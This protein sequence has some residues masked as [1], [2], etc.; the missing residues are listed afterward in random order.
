MNPSNPFYPCSIAFLLLALKLQVQKNSATVSPDSFLPILWQVTDLLSPQAIASS[1]ACCIFKPS[2]QVKRISPVAFLKK[3]P[4]IFTISMLTDGCRLYNADMH[5]MPVLA[6]A[7]ID[8]MA[9][10][11]EPNGFLL[12]HL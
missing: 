1:T 7:A 4:S 2:G 5:N 6:S 8:K 11:S 12:N 10:Y 9:K 3:L